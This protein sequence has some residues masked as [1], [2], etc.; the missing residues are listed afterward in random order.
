MTAPHSVPILTYHHTAEPPTKGSP[1]RSLWVSPASFA[2]QMGWLHRLGFQGLH[3][4]ALLPYVVGEKK[5]KVVGITLDD[6]YLSNLTHALPVLK[7][8]GFSA[9]CYAVSGLLG[10]HN[11]W[12]EALGIA[13]ASLMSPQDLRTWSDAGMEIGSHTCHHADLTQL[14]LD[15]VKK[16]LVQSKADLENILQQAVTQFCYPY[17]H[18]LDAHEAIV[19]QAGYVAA[20][21]TARGIACATDRLTA[22]PR[23][24]IVRSTH[25]AQ[26]FL[27]VMTRYEDSKRT[28]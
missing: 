1:M 25:T 22:L 14:S 9:T 5:G 2:S 21:T 16:E 15:E 11:Q 17:G 23:I 3:I 8:L 4:S 19:S 28:Q 13:K 10:Q 20:T 26:F 18:F 7:R 27:K 12:D 24:P 6:G